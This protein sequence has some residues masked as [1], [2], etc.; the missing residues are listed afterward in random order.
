VHI[1]NILFTKFT[2]LF[3]IQI[4]CPEAHQGNFVAS[5]L[6]GHEK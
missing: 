3:T 2:F 1:V 5:T 6:K 4:P